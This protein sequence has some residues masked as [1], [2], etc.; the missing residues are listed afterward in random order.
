MIDCIIPAAGLS[1][2]M[3]QWK[4]LLPLFNKTIIEWSV[5]NAIEGGCRVILVIG[6]NGER[7]Q[8]LFPEST[9]LTLT[10]NLNYQDGMLSSI[11]TGLLNVKSDHFF[12]SL[13]DMPFILPDIY[14]QIGT[15]Q[16][17]DVVFPK[18]QN[19]TGHPVLIP[20]KF[21]G[22]ILQYQDSNSLKPLLLKLPHQLVEVQ[23]NGIQFDIDTPDEYQKA[24]TKAESILK[25][26]NLLKNMLR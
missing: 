5:S 10:K 6:N 24:L 16:S 1:K 18:Y 26:M 8:K 9:S 23:T 11:K 12:I 3:P 25:N 20:A 7:L 4:P 14:Q 2:R 15:Y 17:N 13:A 22:K 19:K 21:I